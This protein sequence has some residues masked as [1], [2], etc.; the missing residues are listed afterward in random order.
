MKIHILCIVGCSTLCIQS[1]ALGVVRK[2]QGSGLLK[3]LHVGSVRKTT[4]LTRQYSTTTDESKESIFFKHSSLALDCTKRELRVKSRCNK[5]FLHISMCICQVVEDVFASTNWKPAANIK[6]YMHYKEWGRSSNSGKLLSIG[7]PDRASTYIYGVREDQE[8][9]CQE[10]SE[11]PSVILYPSSQ[12][13]SIAEYKDLYH[14]FNS[15]TD[16]VDQAESKK[17]LNVC[18]LDSTWSQCRTMHH[19]LPPH[20]PRV[21]VD[22]FV[23]RASQFLSRK[24]STTPSKVST[25]EA[26]ALALHALGESHEVL[27]KSIFAALRLSVDAG[28]QQGGKEPVYGYHFTPKATHPAATAAASENESVLFTPT[29]V[30]RPLACPSC[31]ATQNET[32][33][34]NRGFVKKEEFA[35]SATG[36]VVGEVNDTAATQDSTS[37]SAGVAATA[38]ATAKSK[39]SLSGESDG[40]VYVRKW[41]CRACN[42]NFTT[43]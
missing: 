4:T 12:A 34:K 24:Q 7:L 2:F 3:G 19:S 5:C 11:S 22:D 39:N 6:I 20:I 43:D 40:E 23:V 1:S 10:L 8:R 28:R 17:L 29:A 26:V 41:V 36:V 25:V 27:E 21:K 38:R 32:R 16:I 15:D 13:V 31:G 30:S 9:L 18:V 14:T 37:A 35:G 33:F 42:T